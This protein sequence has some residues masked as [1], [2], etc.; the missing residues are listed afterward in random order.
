MVIDYGIDQDLQR[1][2]FLVASGECWTY[3]NK[4]IRLVDNATMGRVRKP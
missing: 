4:D 3:A 1:V 2:T